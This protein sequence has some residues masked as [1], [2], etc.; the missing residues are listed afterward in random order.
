MAGVNTDEAITEGAIE[1]LDQSR[2]VV[3]MATKR[4]QSAPPTGRMAK[5]QWKTAVLRARDLPDPWEG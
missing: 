2:G 1:E 4:N 3:G 5:R